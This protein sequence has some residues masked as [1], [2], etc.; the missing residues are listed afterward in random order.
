MSTLSDA[1]ILVG[2]GASLTLV[3]RAVE[4]R[5]RDTLG[6]WTLAAYAGTIGLGGAAV[7]VA[8]VLGL[9][10]SLAESAD[11]QLLVPVSILVTLSSV[12]WLLFTLRYTG[13]YTRFPRTVV[14]AAAAPV[15]LVTNQFLL[16]AVIEAG[17]VVEAFQLVLAVALNL[18]VLGYTT[19]GIYFLLQS[20]VGDAGDL[21]RS[22]ALIAT[23]VGVNACW[24]FIQFAAEM[25][26]PL[27]E[28]VTFA[29]VP[30]IGAVSVT[31]AVSRYSAFASLPAIRRIG[32]RS[33]FDETD[34]PVFITDERDRLVEVNDAAVATG[35]VDAP[36]AETTVET[37]FGVDT[38]T[39]AD[40]ETVTVET[41]AGPRQYDPEVSL[42]RDHHDRKLGAVVSLRDVTD[43][44]LREQRL[45][46][47]NRVLRHNLRNQVD[48]IRAHAELLAD[49][50]AGPP[51]QGGGDAERSE[52]ETL[53]AETPEAETP[54]PGTPQAS[55]G[56]GDGGGASGVADRTAQSSPSEQAS[57]ADRVLSAADEIAQLGESARR[58]DRF[59]SES[60][61]VTTVELSEAV[62]AAVP[63]GDG[64]VI[65]EADGDDETAVG[66]SD[67]EPAVS[68]DESPDDGVVSVRIDVPA[69]ATVVTNQDA[70]GGALE[71][72]IENA[73]E[74]A[75]T[76]VSITVRGLDDGWAVAISDDGPGI[77][78]AE[79]ESLD[80]GT[81]TPLQHGTGLGLWQLK[82]AVTAL[83]GDLSFDTDEGTTVRL[84]VPDRS[85]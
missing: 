11:T 1:V 5:R 40:T 7:G 63:T 24:R 78:S 25:G 66:V 52:M 33:V 67:G 34:D 27:W 26:G 12:L 29:S 17:Q 13:R 49:R 56:A 71:S 18:S 54:E 14:L 64:V 55:D 62:R 9:L 41:T 60:A 84:T 21:R 85:E 76:A 45:S 70:L 74:Y 28:A 42:V 69:G 46:V 31:L 30:V 6:A 8:S 4:I 51:A 81:E 82:W 19:V 79:L 37:V 50:A 10:P 36:P 20:G 22:L 35:V 43:R 15:V 2:V 65:H 75:D 59:V 73:V 57:H 47:L 77:P 39:L 48:V 80:A 68:G 16:S 61:G 23:P 53:E 32:R 3:W 38:A 44:Q 83:N 58:I 72:A